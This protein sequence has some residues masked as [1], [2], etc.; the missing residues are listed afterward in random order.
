ML[1]KLPPF[2]KTYEA[3]SALADGRVL[4]N[5]TGAVV[6]SSGGTAMYTVT[7]EG[8]MYRSDDSATYWQGYPGYPVI[9]LLIL[10]GKLP[11]DPEICALL[12]GVP[13]KKVNDAHKRDYAAAAEEVLG[14]LESKGADINA[15]KTY[16]EEVYEA[17]KKLDIE[18]GRGKRKK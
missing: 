15:V 1:K 11:Y 3:F 2:E 14:G 16:A 17:L 10:E 7:A 4:K 8:N 12:K 5:E 9:A 6:Y 13:W 18:T